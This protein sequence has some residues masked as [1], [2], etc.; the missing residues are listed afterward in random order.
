MRRALFPLVLL[1]LVQGCYLES[2]PVYRSAGIAAGTAVAGFSQRGTASYYGEGFH[3][4]TTASGETYDMYG[5][6]CAHPSLPFGTVLEVLNL[7]NDREV[8]VR[9]NDRGPY[10]GGRIVDLSYGAADRLGMLEAGTASVLLT[11]VGVQEN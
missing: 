7:D 9:V 4:R 8:T 1:F 6:T 11:V 5:L 10:V 3:G 2:K